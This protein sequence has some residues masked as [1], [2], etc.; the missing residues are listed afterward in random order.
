MKWE[1]SCADTEEWMLIFVTTC[2]VSCGAWALTSLWDPMNCVPC[3][4]NFAKIVSNHKSQMIHCIHAVA[5][6]QRERVRF[7]L[8]PAEPI[9]LQQKAICRACH[10]F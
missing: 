2:C 10:H 5:T 6:V 1:E 8:S 9:R 7:Y 4:V 3:R